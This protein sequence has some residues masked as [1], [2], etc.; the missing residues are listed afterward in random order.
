MEPGIEPL[1]EPD[2]ELT[3]TAVGEAE[4]ARMLLDWRGPERSRQKRCLPGPAP[5]RRGRV[6]PGLT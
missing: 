6:G 3:L 1:D 5:A 4:P 2:Q